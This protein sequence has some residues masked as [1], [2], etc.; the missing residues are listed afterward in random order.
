MGRLLWKAL[1]F[2]LAGLAEAAQGLRVGQGREVRGQG[3]HG[4]G[5]LHDRIPGRLLP[6]SGQAFLLR[7][8][9]R[10]VRH[11]YL[12]LRLRPPR[13]AESPAAIAMRRATAL[14][15]LRATFLNRLE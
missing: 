9:A 2:G 8:K 7:F 14:P 10:G 5:M 12:L 11:R 3:Q 13:A 6:L 4:Q 1:Q 15:R